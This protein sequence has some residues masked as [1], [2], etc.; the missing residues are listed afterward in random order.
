MHDLRTLSRLALAAHEPILVDGEGRVPAAVLLLL[1][2]HGGREHVLFQVRTQLVL[3]HKGEIGLPGGR[4][5]P[6]DASLE[7]TALRET[8]EEIGVDPAHVQML[9]RL[10]DVATLSSNYAI[11][12]FV[13][14]ITRPGAY[15]FRTARREVS[16][17][18]QVPLDH[19][20]GE[21]AV[22]W[23]VRDVEGERIAERSFR[24]GEHLIWGA[25]ARM[26][27]QYLDLLSEAER[28]QRRYEG[29]RP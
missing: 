18:L 6:E 19:L 15:P 11:T 14:A 4:R 1:Y 21:D 28:G 3:H 2:A 7:A 23:A 8:H 24:Y 10:D 25:T 26:V 17:L 9:G 12:P 13:G 16:E 27:G 5:D 29:A 22:E 20:R